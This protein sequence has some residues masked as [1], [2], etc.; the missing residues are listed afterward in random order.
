M[1]ARR[2]AL[3]FHAPIEME[4]ALQGFMLMRTTVEGIEEAP[5]GSIFYFIPREE[6]SG[7]LESDITTFLSQYPDSEF[8]GSELIEERD[9]NAEWE[10][11]ITPQRVTDA[12]VIT[13]SWK[14]EEARSLGA[15]HLIV[16]DPKM[17]FGTGHHETTRLCLRAIESL[18]MRN[19]SVLDI[20]TGSGV[21]A[22]YALLRGA[23]HAV[24][25]DTDQWSIENA[26]ENRALNNIAERDLEIRMGTVSSAIKPEE[27]F[28]TILANIH[29]NVLIEIANEIAAHCNERTC[30][31]L[32]GLLIYD[33][34]EVRSAYESQGFQL[35]SEMREN[36]W[37]CLVMRNWS[38]P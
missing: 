38:E 37:V 20:G 26:H 33:V 9:W 10:S 27:R 14:Q 13:P 19:A 4:D 17:S 5:D 32:S 21:L 30:V 1:D 7:E 28:D 12:L 2:T 23:R 29:R 3:K 11:S 22:I 8:L 6:W 36:E 16:I 31:I 15:E 34:E 25:I 35:I 18:D 24:A